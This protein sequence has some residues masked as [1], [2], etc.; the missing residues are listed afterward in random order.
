MSDVDHLKPFEMYM[1]KRILQVF[2]QGYHRQIHLIHPHE[3]FMILRDEKTYYC[4]LHYNKIYIL[5]KA[6]N[7]FSVFK[8]ISSVL[9]K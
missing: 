7:K 8:N 1:P 5:V 2:P 3:P 4:I 6:A 9:N